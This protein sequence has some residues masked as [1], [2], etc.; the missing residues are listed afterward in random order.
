MIRSICDH[1]KMQPVVQCCR[2]HVNYL[3]Q[4]QDIVRVACVDD[5]GIHRSVAV[6]EI[7]QAVC[8]RRGYNTHGPFHME[9]PRWKEDEFCQHCKHCDPND[10]KEALYTVTADYCW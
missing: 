3:L 9:Q 10:N 6:A 1:D 7:L 4:Q 2:D 8:K 5:R